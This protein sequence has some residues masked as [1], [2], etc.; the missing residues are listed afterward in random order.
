MKNT[1]YD[2]DLLERFLRYVKI[3]SPADPESGTCPSTKYQLEMAE[4]LAAD[5]KAIGLSEVKIDENGFV[6]GTLEGNV[7]GVPT[8]GFIAHMDTVH[9]FNGLGVKPRVIEN[10]DGK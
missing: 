3:D 4:V 2:K 6:T 5:L 8:I 10:Y 1:S 7:E 9:T